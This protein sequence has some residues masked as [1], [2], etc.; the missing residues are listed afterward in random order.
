[1]GNFGRGKKEEEGASKGGGG[2]KKNDDKVCLLDA[3]NLETPLHFFRELLHIMSIS[4]WH[5]HSLDTST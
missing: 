5:N 1:M 3:N 2:G 4:G